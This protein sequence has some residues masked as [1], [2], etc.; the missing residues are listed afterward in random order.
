MHQPSGTRPGLPP[1]SNQVQA[2]KR[3]APL[4]ALVAVDAQPALVELADEQV[5]QAV[6]VEVA[7]ERGGVAGASD[8]DGHAAGGEFHRRRPAPPA[9][10]GPRR[11]RHTQTGHRRQASA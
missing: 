8:V 3:G 7:D 10:A 9:G 1:A 11:R 4:L 2:S 5:G 6:A